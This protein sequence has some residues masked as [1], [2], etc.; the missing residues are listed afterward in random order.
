MADSVTSD[1]ISQP[2]NIYQRMHAIAMELKPLA[3]D[4][5]VKIGNNGGYGYISHDAVTLAI[6]DVI[7]SHGVMPIPTVVECKNDGN[8]AEMKI[9]VAFVNIDDPADRIESY[10]IG[11]GVDPSDKGP[12]KAFSYATKIL[13]LKTF[14]LNTGEDI[15]ERDDQ[16]DPATPRGSQIEAAQQATR[17]AIEVAA[18]NLKAAIDGAMTTKE[19]V[20]IQRDN[21]DW[22]M[23]IPE[24]TRDYF[25]GLIQTKKTQIEGGK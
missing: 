22:F 9:R 3:K 2:M 23:Q 14:L 7:L 17:D 10:T 15:E 18:K 11:Y 16:H 8:R 19:L 12:G 4:K 25:I 20:A 5:E 6:R 24:V 21:K 13:Y 1:P